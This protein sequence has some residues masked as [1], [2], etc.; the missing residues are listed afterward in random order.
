M[1]MTEGK[2]EMAKIMV[3]PLIRD[4]RYAE[5]GR[6]LLTVDDLPKGWLDRYEKDVASVSHVIKRKNLTVDHLH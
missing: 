2:R 3:A 4:L 1:N 5:I 6:K